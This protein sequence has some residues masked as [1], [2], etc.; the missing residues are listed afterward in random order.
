MFLEVGF[1]KCSAMA[2]VQ[3]NQAIPTAYVLRPTC[4]IHQS[5]HYSKVNLLSYDR[6]PLDTP[7]T[8]NVYF[9]PIERSELGRK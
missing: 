9:L 8:S 5:T 2:A 1:F 6:S 7:S 3:T 4:N